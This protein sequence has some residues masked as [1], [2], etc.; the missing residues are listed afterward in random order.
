MVLAMIGHEIEIIPAGMPCT[1]FGWSAIYI[2][3]FSAEILGTL[4]DAPK[5]EFQQIAP[6]NDLII[7]ERREQLAGDRNP[8]RA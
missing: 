1:S 8:G 4:A 7:C 2:I 6:A 5:R 3:P